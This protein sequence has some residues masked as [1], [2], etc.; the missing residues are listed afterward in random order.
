[1]PAMS[2]ALDRWYGW[3]LSG[4]LLV[5][6]TAAMS[7]V[8]VALRQVSGFNHGLR[9]FGSD[10]DE[11]AAWLATGI[12]R[13]RES[14]ERTGGRIFGDALRSEGA[15]HAFDIPGGEVLALTQRLDTPDLSSCW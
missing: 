12:N 13:S 9:V 1:M 5:L 10:N 14:S 8:L 6:G 3:W 11:I 7:V 4:W 15:T 2:L